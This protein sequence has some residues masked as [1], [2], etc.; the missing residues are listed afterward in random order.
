MKIKGDKERMKRIALPILIAAII[1]LAT[2]CG[3]PAPTATQAPAVNPPATQAPSQP[4]VADTVPAPSGTQVEV[5]LEDN[6]I[7]AS[8]AT[9][10]T[11]VKYTFVIT[12]SG[13][14]A[15]NFNINPPVSVVGSLDAALTQALLTVPQEKL[16][17]GSSVT[18]DYTFPA[19]AVGQQLEF[20]CLIRRHY[21]DG[22]FLSITVTQ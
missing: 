20:S 18:V 12:N 22:M 7:S 19:T 8:Q 2:A 17:V 1:L 4:S 9:F 14:H 16:S 11:G 3:S 10:Q 5:T 15:H 13:H 6:T 21:E